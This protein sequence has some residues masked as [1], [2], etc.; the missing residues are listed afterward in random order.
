MADVTI[1]LTKEQIQTIVDMC[2]LTL[3]TGGIANLKAVNEIL[4]ALKIDQK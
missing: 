1:K 4:K 3:K 2:D